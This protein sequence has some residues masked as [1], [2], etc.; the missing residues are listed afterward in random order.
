[1]RA[2]LIVRLSHQLI[3]L[4]AKQFSGKRT[5]GV[6]GVICLL[7]ALFWPLMGNAAASEEV[8]IQLKWFHQFQFAG[9]YAAQEKGYFAEEGLEVTLR[10]RDPAT[11]HINDVLEGKAEYGVADAGLVLSRL[12]GKPVVLLSQVFQHSPLILMALKDSGIRTP[13]D[14]AGKTIMVDLEG[15][16]DAPLNAMLL[17]TL[18]G[19]DSVTIKPHS[20]RN[21]DL[22]EGKVDAMVGYL[23]DQPYWF[24]QRGRPVTV[25]DPRDYG[26]DFYGDNLF[27]T[28][29][30]IRTHP[31]RVEKVVRAVQRGWAYALEHPEEIIDLILTRYDTRNLSRDHLQFEALQTRNII[32]PKFIEIGTYEPARFSKMAEVYALLGFADHAKVDQ[33]FFHSPD[34][35]EQPARID[36]VSLGLTQEER[37]WIRNH[38]RI[39]VHN[40]TAWPPF[41]FAE[42]NKPMGFSIDFMNLLAKK[43]GLQ[44]EYVTGP[45]W[46]E[47]LEMMKRGDL[48]V[49]LNIV[50]TP[51]RLK[52]LLYTP[53]YAE[54]PNTILSRVDTSYENLEQL[55]GKTVSVPKGFFYEEVLKRDF[56]QIMILPLTT[57]LDTIKAVSFGKADAALG[58]LA[59]FNHL[60]SQHMISDLAV[61]GEVRVGNP[62]LALL[63]I[64]TRKDLPVLVSILTKG[65]KA[66]TV[67][68]RRALKVKWLQTDAMSK[69]RLI[70]LTS[71]EQAWLNAHPVIRMGGG[72]LTPLDGKGADGEVEGIARDYADLIATK[73]GIRFEHSAGIWADVHQQARE[74]EI[75]GIRLLAPNEERDRYLNFTQP[76][77]K[78]SY[79]F[80][81]RDSAEQITSIAGLTDKRLATLKASFDHGYLAEHYPELN[82]VPYA[83]Y[84]DGI[85]AVFN[86]EANAFFGVLPMMDHL[87]RTQ[88]IPGLRISSVVHEFPSPDLVIGVREEWPEFIPILNKAL[89]AITVDERSAIHSKWL[90]GPP[91]P[92]TSIALT[93]EE[94]AWITDHPVIKVANDNEWP[95]FDYFENNKAKGYSMDYLRALAE[96]I[97]IKLEFIQD[98]NWGELIKRFEN[99]QLDVITAY[100]GSPEREQQFALFTKPYLSIKESIIV[101]NDSE[102]IQNY[103]QLYGKKVAVIKGYDYED[104]IKN[105][106]PEIKMV[107]VDTPVEGLKKVSH[108]EADALLENSAVADYLMHKYQLQNLKLAGDPAFPGIES[109]DQLRIATR[110]DWPVLH[111]LFK[112]AMQAISD[113]T[114]D[115][116]E[117]KWLQSSKQQQLLSIIPPDSVKFDSANFVMRS[118]ALIL[119][120]IVAVIIVAWFVRGRPKH[121]TIRESLFLIAFVFA[122]LIISIGAFVTLLLE[123]GKQQ[124]EIEAIKYDSYNL[125]LELKQS[126]DDLTR[127]ARTYAVT[128][129]PRYVEYFHMILDIRDG[130]RPHPARFTQSYWDHVAAGSAEINEDGETY[131]IDQKLD[132][133]GFSDQEKAKILEA[134]QASD[135]LVE[136]ETIAMNA[137]RGKF[138][139]AEGEFSITGEPDLE[140]ART[141]LHGEKYHQSKSQ[142]MKPID[143]FFIL[144]EWRTTNS[145]NNVRAKNQAILWAIIGLTLLTIGYAVYAFFLFKRRIIK[146]LGYLEEGTRIIQQGDYSHRLSLETKDE[147]SALAEA[148]NAM[149]ASINERTFLMRG[150]INTAV[151]AIVVTDQDSIIKEFSPSAERMFGHAAADVVGRNV[152]LIV[153][154]ELRE[155]HKAGVKRVVEGAE[156][157]LYNQTVELPVLHKDGRIFPADFSV[158]G[159]RHNGKQF[160]VAIIRDISERKEADRALRMAE[161][162]SRL[163][164]D[165]VGEGIF[166]VDTKGRLTF[167]NPAGTR[168]VGFTAEEMMGQGVHKLI[169]HTRPDGSHYPVTECP[170]YDAYTKGI[171]A[172]RDSDLLWRKDGS[173]FSAEYSSVPLYKDDTL[174]GAVFVFRDITERKLAEEELRKLSKAVEQS[175]ASIVIT[176]IEGRIEYVNP[177]FC[178]LTGYTVEEAVGQN[179][180]ILSSG[181]NPPE[182]YDD[183][184]KAL[185]AGEEWSGEFINK[186]K[187][188]E[189]YWEHASLS[190]I[191]NEEGE[192]VQYLAVKDDIT[193]RKRMESEILKAKEQAED[194]TRAKSDFLANMSHEIRTPMNAIIGMSG[195][196][197]KT[198]LDNKQYN[199]ISKVNRSAESLLGIIND[200]LDFSKIEA[201]KMDMESIDFRLEDVMDNL[202]SLVGLKAEERGVEFLFDTAAN[203][204]TALVGDPL[205]LGQILVNLGNNAVKFTEKGEVVITTRVKEVSDASVTLH[206]AVRDSGIGMTAEQQKQLFQ[207]FSQ[208]DSSTTRKYGGTGLGLAISKSLS[209]MMG[210]EIWVESE[211]GVGST[212]QFTATFGRQKGEKVGRVKPELAD[213]QGL[214]VLAVDDNATAREILVDIFDSFAFEV[215]AFNSG[216]T[217]LEV[218]D[219]GKPFD[220]V[221]MDWMMPQMD[222]VETTRLI[223][224]RLD[225]PPPVIM[226]TSYGREEAMDATR[227]INL[228][229]ILSKPV[230]PSTLLDAIM[231]TFGHEEVS[232]SRGGHH[233]QVE[234]EAA[235]RVRGSHILL[236]EDNEIN[237]ELAL[238]LLAGGGITA[239]VAMNG[240][241]AL[242]ILQQET[243]DGVLMDCQMPVMD[244]YEAT[245]EIRKQEKYRDLPVIAMT[246]NVMAGDRE[247]VLEAG[248]NDHIGKPINVRE[249]FTTIAKWITP[250]MEGGVE[251]KSRELDL[252][253]GEAVEQEI[254]ELAG[255]NVNAGLLTTQNNPA[256]YRKLLL[257]FYDSHQDFEQQFQ[258]A[259]QDEDPNAATRLAHSLKGV[260]GNLGIELVQHAAEILEKACEEGEENI[261]EQIKVVVDELIPV[262]DGLKSL[263]MPGAGEGM[264]QPEQSINLDEVD[265]LIR[266]LHQQISDNSF[267]VSQTLE[268]I[269]PLLENTAYRTELDNLTDAVEGYEFDVA[270]EELEALIYRLGIE[271]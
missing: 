216:K 55:F 254:P 119:L 223:Q 245:R 140:M 249:M 202:A 230:T 180:R 228:S 222:G 263:Q 82:L 54:N 44:V 8:S 27:T 264:L 48:D 4:A 150:V 31:E 154:P 251:T 29:E 84:A 259:R 219:S 65:V 122:G 121:L 133:L 173:S 198:K 66:I 112:K 63:N 153:P 137:V 17:K 149:S 256:L 244:G 210:G 40:E 237:Q 116:L 248:M 124:S 58:E 59:V 72:I 160:F 195:L 229:A 46:N 41:N 78:L 144:L 165:S 117:H 115:K 6:I 215:Q 194:A 134:K 62:E 260:A 135:A 175:S 231:K 13:F 271:I 42:N 99:K 209:E 108:G 25:L 184:W 268:K 176:D 36:D 85:S 157:K 269:T 242:E 151:D 39:R 28:E 240:Q 164:L 100:E 110:K 255:I 47:F 52:Y 77:S 188:G 79:G 170:M 26:I 91:E 145:L 71:D 189:L 20:Y 2:T 97:G 19:L 80:V 23:T 246:A 102:F 196:A 3:A 103:K 143:D 252:P 193:E 107:L 37:D 53:P 90:S 158:G 212:F 67:E 152:E 147:A 12:Q 183:L 220:L 98:D 56:P 15:N 129:D 142:I 227:G 261:D 22:L 10:Q 1:M 191:K 61:T 232:V 101:R 109:G 206:F 43:S 30:E 18:G 181:K 221:I 21:E 73:L 24:E 226:V 270:M 83:T 136:L 258:E 123:G 267:T 178:D 192:I 132:E 45:S 51:E 70:G 257:R 127:F 174:T 236:V 64:A 57:T 250:S 190:P 204:P 200:I 74:K 218:L 113:E 235:A 49:M 16:S 92:R 185:T 186:K 34:D 213:I 265:P 131:S 199:Y 155:A 95:P 141:L 169:H 126:S 162:R 139:D 118:I 7:P 187:N 93:A 225:S 81:M 128:G 148:F 14:L 197:L 208:V 86:G 114:L 125:A 238:E 35:S 5:V 168:M 172:N 32:L 75:D 120:A 167:I 217:A 146:P 87:I 247:K 253:P 50:K 211:Q 201:G 262:L 105:N 166:G 138:R 179:P 88:A 234:V 94:K 33:G 171:S 38:P 60:L 104:E 69:P 68:E 224:E 161:E 239:K 205:R 96:I 203:V 111:G 156:P 89:S 106:H 233:A 11:S 266:E 163:L 76:Y 177:R 241:E 243:F 130:K 182:V 207:S 9:Y 214:R 159:W